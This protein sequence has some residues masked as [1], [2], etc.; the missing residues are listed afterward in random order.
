[1][2]EKQNKLIEEITDLAIEKMNKWP[3]SRN[4]QKQFILGVIG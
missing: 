1:M 3:S 4:R 2:S